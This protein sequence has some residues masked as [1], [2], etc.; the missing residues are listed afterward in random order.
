MG[1]FKKIVDEQILRGLI[2]VLVLLLGYVVY[3]VF[4]LL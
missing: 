2:A 4:A 3:R 1:R